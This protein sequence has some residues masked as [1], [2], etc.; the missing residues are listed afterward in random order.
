MLIAIPIQANVDT[1][2]I[3][4]CGIDD[5]VELYQADFVELRHAFNLLRPKCPRDGP[6]QVQ[7]LGL[8]TTQDLIDR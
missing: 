3:H 2:V 5:G 7:R 4:Q 1:G 8:P 6:R